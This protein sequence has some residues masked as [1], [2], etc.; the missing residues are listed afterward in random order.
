ME[1]LD[2]AGRALGGASRIVEGK[3]TS[4]ETGLIKVK[5]VT[6][7][8]IVPED[9]KVSIIQLDVEGFEEPAVRGALMTIHRC[10]PTLILETLPKESFLIDH[11]LTSG[12]RITGQVHG[13]TVLR[14]G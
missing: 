8:E 5:I 7:D 12:Y 11:L 13:N 1:T 10:N 14:C 2:V 4:H 6:V 3:S 9:R